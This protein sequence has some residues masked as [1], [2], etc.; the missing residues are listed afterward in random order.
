MD[1]K[2][3]C[4][5]IWVSMSVLRNYQRSVESLEKVI[6]GRLTQVLSTCSRTR[7]VCDADRE[8]FDENSKSKLIQI[9]D[10]FTH[11]QT[12]KVHRELTWQKF[13]IFTLHH[14]LMRATV[15]R[16]QFHQHHQPSLKCLGSIRRITAEILHPRSMS[17]HN[18]AFSST[19]EI[20]KVINHMK[21]EVRSPRSTALIFTS[22]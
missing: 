21:M 2:I 8:D 11:Q 18:R 12:T 13:R 5:I 7:E 1:G 6:T 16:L 3:L 17:L 10:L 4:V 9:L 20:T 22:T 19:A 15:Q 14:I